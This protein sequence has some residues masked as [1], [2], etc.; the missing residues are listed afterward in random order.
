MLLSARPSII[1]CTWTTFTQPIDHFTAVA[2]GGTFGQRAC[3]YDKFWGG[4]QSGTIF[5]YTGNESPVEEY[6]NNTGLM[7]ELGPK[8]GALLVWAEHRYEPLTHPDLKGSENCFAFGTTAQAL[9]DYASIIATLRKEYS[10][11][12]A[13]AI[14]FGGSYGG[15]LAGWMRTRYPHVLA[16]AI[17]AS[18]PVWGL[19][20]TME[21]DRLDWSHRAI[22]RAISSKGGA[23]D[24][25]L[26]NVRSAWP[27]L[28][29]IGKSRQALPLLGQ[30]A[31]SCHPLSSVSELTSWARGPWFDMAEGDYPFASTY[32]T[33]S[34]GPGYIPL[35][36][37]PLRVACAN[38]LD[39]D[40]GV[41]VEGDVEAVRYNVTIGEGESALRVAV[42]WNVSTPAWSAELSAA[43]V[44][45]SGILPLVT[46]LR[47]AVGVW[48]NITKDKT[49]Y[50]FAD[51]AADARRRREQPR[52]ALRRAATA[53]SV[54]A[55]QRSAAAASAA[56]ASTAVAEDATT[57]MVEAAETPGA[58]AVA[59]AAIAASACPA[60]PP[61]EGCPPCPIANC[62]PGVCDYAG[63]LSKTFS[64]T[65]VTCNED[66]RLYNLDVQG[67]GHDLWWPP[68]TS[69]RHPTVEDVVGPHRLTVGCGTSEGRR[70]LYGAPHQS[71][72][73]S[74]WLTAY[75][76]GSNV[77]KLR[78]IVWS[79]GLLDPWSGGGVYPPGGGIDGPTIQSLNADG[80][81][82][83]LLISEGAHHLDLFFADDA[84]PPSAKHARD[85]EAKII[86]Q[87]ADEWRRTGAAPHAV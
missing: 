47:D 30:A 23:T 67:L 14:A 37:W 81:Q 74:A 56:A 70:G 58:S 27:L 85:V 87:W 35:P 34:V 50:D 82:I 36:P 12:S 86:Q 2:G 33:Y 31:R 43:Q 13:P 4:D 66:L 29:E 3:V 52:A 42:D 62:V 76:G 17:A 64:W 40:L 75:Y 60:C 19:A 72:P 79:N 10:T 9:E 57:T 48:Y 68:S 38:G 69:S 5:F 7:W 24:R 25:C 63:D 46:A 61:C 53:P 15:M 84:D 8:M 1:N 28:A 26:A 51:D 6:V 80:S 71:D 59:P 22:A 55:Q 32:I 39:G 44:E 73:W 20:T 11:P 65:T 77:S 54:K 78:N 83:A 18:A 21:D 16:G 49:C 41:S 45:A